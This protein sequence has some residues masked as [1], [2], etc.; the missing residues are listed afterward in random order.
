MIANWQAKAVLR[1]LQRKPQ[2]NHIT[3]QVLLFNQLKR[4]PFGRVQC[5]ICLHL[6]ISTGH[7]VSCNSPNQVILQH[8]LRSSGMYGVEILRGIHTSVHNN[9]LSTTRMVLQIRSRIIHLLV[10]NKPHGIFSCML[11]HL[12]PRNRLKLLC[13]FLGCLRHRC[14]LWHN[15]V[16]P[17]SLGRASSRRMLKTDPQFA[18]P[19]L[20]MTLNTENRVVSHSHE[21]PCELLG[22]CV[23]GGIP[24]TDL[25][26]W[27]LQHIH[28]VHLVLPEHPAPILVVQLG[29]VRTL[30]LGPPAVAQLPSLAVVERD[31]H[32]RH[33]RPTT[34][35]CISANQ[36][37]LFISAYKCIMPGVGNCRVDVELIE[38][39][40]RLVPP[41]FSLCQL[42]IHMWR[43]DAVVKEM[44]VVVRGLFGHGDVGHP[45]DHPPTNPTWNDNAQWVSVVCSQIDAIH[46]PGDQH[47]I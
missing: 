47:I 34:R 39:I 18:L 45:L 46:L 31:L 37:S 33:F 43:H 14:S 23:V 11:A 15:A 6:S 32:T 26:L 8:G 42:S 36:I 41:S 17:T 9:T 24:G 40:L 4:N 29:C 35:V 20:R 2:P 19:A 3:A 16:H 38:E 25:E 44:I 13:L 27:N 12:L 10:H 1:A 30:L 28:H 21:I 7:F 22:L 5:H